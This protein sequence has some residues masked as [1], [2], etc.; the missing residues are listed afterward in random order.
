MSS[1]IHSDALPRIRRETI[2]PNL[3]ADDPA[4]LIGLA[5]SHVREGVGLTGTV[6]DTIVGRLQS[7]ADHGNPACRLL[8]DWLARRNRDL[9][10]SLAKPRRIR[11]RIR[12]RRQAGPGSLRRRKW[13][14]GQSADLQTAIIAATTEGRIDG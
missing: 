5:L 10:A 11:R 2:S 14:T 1:D 3:L 4:I 9:P 12:E 13:G 6:P 8:L 7:H